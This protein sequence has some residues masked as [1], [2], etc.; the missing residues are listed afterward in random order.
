MHNYFENKTEINTIR[1]SQGAPRCR[2]KHEGFMLKI[3]SKFKKFQFGTSGSST[4][5]FMNPFATS[6]GTLFHELYYLSC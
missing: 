3:Q 5:R 1:L 2:F 4:I 6:M